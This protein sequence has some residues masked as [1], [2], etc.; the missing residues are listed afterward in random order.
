ML[1]VVDLTPNRLSQKGSLF[2]FAADLTP[3]QVL[4]GCLTQIIIKKVG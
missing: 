1:K 3:L 2:F 4:A